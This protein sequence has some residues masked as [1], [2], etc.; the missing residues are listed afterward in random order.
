MHFGRLSMAAALAACLA[1]SLSACTDDPEPG[2]TPSSRAGTAGPTAAATTAPA[3]LTPAWQQEAN[4]ESIAGQTRNTLIKVYPLQRVSGRVLLTADIVAKGTPGQKLNGLNYFCRCVGQGDLQDVSLV[5]TLNR[6]RYGPLRQGSKTGAT[7]ASNINYS[8]HDVGT[9]YRVGAFFPDPGPGV[10]TMG[11]DL[12]LGGIAPAIPIVDG[13]TTAP[14]LLAGSLPADSAT[15]APTDSATATTAPTAEA[16]PGATSTGVPAPSGGDANGPLTTWTVPVP[17]SDAYVDRHDLVAKVVGGTVNEGGGKKQ[18]IVTLNADVLFAFD[19]AKLSGKASGLIGE[20]RNVLSR[21][22]D[23]AK[24]VT[25]T[26]YTDGKGSPTY[27]QTLSEQRASA[28]KKALGSVGSL[29]LRSEG[30]GENDPVAPNTKPDGADNPRG[31]A[32]NRRVEIAYSPKPAPEPTTQAPAP[33]ATG[34]AGA[35]GTA[36]GGSVT[37]PPATVKSNGLDPTTITATVHPIVQDG[38]FSL[39]TLDI[40]DPQDS[41]L[42]DAFTSHSKAD[43]DIGAFTIVDPKTER[44]YVPAYDQ[45]DKTRVMGTFT[46][47]LSANQPQHL[48]FYAAELPQSLTAAT[49]DLGPLGAAKNV[50]VVR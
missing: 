37:L 23:P 3:G 18:G 32:L 36:A 21:K 6:V 30:Q 15:A 46:H 5:D 16:Q 22:A 44:V 47:R 41:L 38:T 43:Q 31:R 26:G 19:S 34:T 29:K 24:P 20:A 49:V 27:N 1:I 10:S 40:V 2:P 33:A 42:L 25:V 13:G 9:T 12:Q 14:G 45:D 4:F 7:Y 28:V 50:P 48:A 17:G 39:V 35:T 8:F 11:V